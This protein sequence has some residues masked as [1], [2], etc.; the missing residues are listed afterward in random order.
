MADRLHVV[1]DGHLRDEARVGFARLCCGCHV[2]AESIQ[3]RREL[4][5]GRRLLFRLGQPG[6]IPAGWAV[7]T[8]G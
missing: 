7:V 5:G 8:L 6:G 1:H 2:A 4:P 3:I